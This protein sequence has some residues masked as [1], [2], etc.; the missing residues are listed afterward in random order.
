VRSGFFFVLEIYMRQSDLGGGGWGRRGAPTAGVAVRAARGYMGGGRL[1]GGGAVLDGEFVVSRLTAAAF[2]GGRWGGARR[3]LCGESEA[4]GIGSAVE[5]ASFF[6]AGELFSFCV[7]DPARDRGPIVF[8]FFFFFGV[9]RRFLP[10]YVWGGRGWAS[11]RT[12][13][14]RGQPGRR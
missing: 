5:G 12:F 4:W 11:L 10:P 13:F 2:G 3:F 7:F 14:R 9:F 8:L 6:F 1:E